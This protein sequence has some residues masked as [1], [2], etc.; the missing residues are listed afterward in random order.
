MCNGKLAG[1]VSFG[2]ENKCG[3]EH[4]PGVYTDVS[5]FA[6]VIDQTFRSKIQRQVC[7]TYTSVS[8]LT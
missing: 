6:R 2:P 1:V 3:S 8:N 5:I 7:K 4:L